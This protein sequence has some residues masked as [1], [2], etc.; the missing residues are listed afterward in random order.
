[1]TAHAVAL[2][3][4]GSMLLPTAVAAQQDMVI[5]GRIIGPEG[6]ALPGQP[7]M[8]HRV[9]GGAGATIAEATADSTGRFRLGVAEQ[10][11]TTAIYFVA[12][13]H[14]GELYIGRAF[15]IGE[16]SAAEQVIQVGVPGTSA[17]A[18]LGGGVAAAQPMG[19]AVT[20]RNWL[21]LL[22]PLLGVSAV[23][24]FALLRSARMPQDRALLIRVAELDERM[25]SAPGAQRDTMLEERGRL[26]AQLRAD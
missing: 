26:M 17:S 23:A 15:R 9:Q 14:E 20:N 24:V 1:M 7:V 8:L 3:L 10:T 12:T 18:L 4:A 11:D 13:R 2:L 6:A 19:R 22:I 21:L 16:P 5:Q 25:A